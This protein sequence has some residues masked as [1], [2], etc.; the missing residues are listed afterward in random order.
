MTWQM[1]WG[2]IIVGI[3]LLAIFVWRMTRKV[4][5]LSFNDITFL[6]IGICMLILGLYELFFGPS[7]LMERLR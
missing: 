4:R 5:I 2:S 3:L 6:G 1:T 7:D